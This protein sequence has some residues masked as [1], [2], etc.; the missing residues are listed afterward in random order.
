[1]RLT[2]IKDDEDSEEGDL[3]DG[4][5]RVEF[6]E[7]TSKELYLMYLDW[8]DRYWLDLYNFDKQMKNSSVVPDD[9]LDY[10]CPKSL[11]NSMNLTGYFNPILKDTLIED[12]PN[13]ELSCCTPHD[14]AE[15]DELWDDQL[16]PTTESSHFYLEYFVKST[17]E[18]RELYKETAHKLLEYTK[19]DMC[20]KIAKSV[21]DR[22]VTDEEA[23]EILQLLYKVKDYDY[24]VKK[25]Y[26][27]LV[28]NHANIKYF[29]FKNRLLG[30]NLNICEDIVT[31]LLP[32]HI[33]FN[34]LYWKYF[35]TLYFMAR[36][37]DS[38]FDMEQDEEDKV[39]EEIKETEEKIHEEEPEMESSHSVLQIVF[40]LIKCF[41]SQIFLD[42]NKDILIPIYNN[43][44]KDIYF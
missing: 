42:I 19:D 21:I 9:S 29:D 40:S 27:C 2:Q 44:F 24:Q 36:C 35:N 38:T 34:E 20:K 7:N 4:I 25:S 13:M 14:F 37:V 10:N 28:C 15:L 16:G 23:E 11:L 39:I 6:M 32:Y 12:C 8:E 41:Y 26:N 18:H 33:K 31:N 30:L 43:K 5:Q 3:P 17:L 22:P 1:M